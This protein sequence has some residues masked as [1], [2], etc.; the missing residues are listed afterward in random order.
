MAMW[1]NDVNAVKAERTGD[2]MIAASDKASKPLLE[3]AIGLVAL[4]VSMT[5]AGTGDVQVLRVLRVLRGKIDDVT[6]G[7]H[8]ALS[9]SIGMFATAILV[10]A[11]KLKYL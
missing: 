1:S 11:S 10:I 3:M 8:M 2:L 5:V 7:T 9:M 4:A 6:F